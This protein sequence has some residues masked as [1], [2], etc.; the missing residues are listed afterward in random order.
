MEDGRAEGAEDEWTGLRK[1]DGR[2]GSR[3]ASMG[4]EVLKAT[5]VPG[6]RS[7]GLFSPLRGELDCR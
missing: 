4:Q 5:V 1:G 7:V 2:L 6:C 3:Q